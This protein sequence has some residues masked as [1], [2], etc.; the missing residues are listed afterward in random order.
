MAE[1]HGKNLCV[2]SHGGQ[3][4]YAWRHRPVIVAVSNE[5]LMRTACR[6]SVALIFAGIGCMGVSFQRRRPSRVT[7]RLIPLAMRF[8]GQVPRLA[9]LFVKL[10]C[11]KAGV[12]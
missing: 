8:A 3:T 5:T 11:R 4:D 12:L 2:T 9:F 6:P 7:N 10:D 1:S